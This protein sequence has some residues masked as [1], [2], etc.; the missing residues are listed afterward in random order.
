[1]RLIIDADPGLGTHG[2][3]PEDALAVLY[4]LGSP[5]VRLEGLT[6]VHGNVPVSHS[7]P[8]IENLLA[9]L[10]RGDLP[11]HLG[12]ARPRDPDRRV[13]QTRW[14]AY[15][16][17]TP[18]AV[19]W[20]GTLPEPSATEFLCETVLGSPGEITLAAIGPLTNVAE[21]IEA[22]PDFAH[23]LAGLVVMGGTVAVPG[24]ITPAAEFN[25]WMDP[26]AADVVFRSGAAIAMVGLDVCHRTRFDRAM[27]ASVRASGSPLASFVADG[28][29]AWIEVM[30]IAAEG[31]PALHLY[32]SLAV[33]AAVE[34]G[35][36]SMRPALVEIE[37][38]TGPAQGMTVTYLDDIRRQLLT[39]RPHN[40]SVAVDV[41]LDRF[42]TLFGE[43]VLEAL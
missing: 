28:C 3:D 27:A 11:V 42:G 16:E 13:H 15:R 19:P 17:A 22:E 36:L 6:L 43:R 30:A 39:G 18:V 24:N 7:W 32:D 34:P 21:A 8:N 33:A 2:A 31:G 12:A 37:T 20:S 41:D 35:L 38:S 14:L 40:A 9:L 5:D 25:V 26:E 10:G 23:C 29:G 1:M 4:A